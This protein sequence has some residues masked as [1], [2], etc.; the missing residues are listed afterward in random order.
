MTSIQTDQVIYKLYGYWYKEIK[1][2]QYIL[3]NC[4]EIHISLTDRKRQASL[5]INKVA[6][7]LT[8]RTYIVYFFYDYIILIIFMIRIY[9]I[10]FIQQPNLYC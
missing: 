3:N 5:R 9:P 1:K 2:Q 4:Q 7:A 8:S 6:K 10:S